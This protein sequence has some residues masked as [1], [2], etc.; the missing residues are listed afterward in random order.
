MNNSLINECPICMDDIV[1]NTN[2]VVTECGHA[3]HCSC[4]MRNAC[5][6]GFGCP[7]CRTKMAEKPEEDEE[8][9]SIEEGN[10]FND[11]VLT[12]F[13]MFHQQINNEDVE[14]EPEEDDEVEEDVED[15]KPDADYVLQKLIERGV[16]MKDLVTDILFQEHSEWGEYYA[17]YERRSSEIF[18]HFRAVLS[19]YT[20]QNNNINV[21]LPAPDVGLSVE[22]ISME[23][24]IMVLQELCPR[25]SHPRPRSSQIQC[26]VIAES[27][28][29]NLPIQYVESI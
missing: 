15:L 16:T 25:S 8:D 11:D 23:Y 3:F 6:N 17:D 21:L 20:P 24:M 10:D 29:N 12:S 5:Q 28:E 4:L 9:D 13:R 7:Y 14:E 26:P 1:A 27:K 19:Q 18:G 22:E 2:R